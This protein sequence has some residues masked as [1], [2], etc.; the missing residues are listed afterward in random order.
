[1]NSLVGWE[2]ISVAIDD[3]ARRYA[4][5]FA[6]EQ[7]TV[8]KGKQV[9]FNTLAVCALSH[10]L[11]WL[12]IAFSLSQSDCWQPNLRSIFN[13]SDLFLPD[14]GCLECRVIVGECEEIEIVRSPKDDCLGYVI[15]RLDEDLL[16]VNL[17]GFLS[18]DRVTAEVEIIDIDRLQSLDVLL[19]TIDRHRRVNNLKQWWVDR[20]QSEW[21]QPELLL[22]GSGGYFR[23]FQDKEIEEERQ[24]PSVSRGKIIEFD[25]DTR[26]VLIL[27]ITEISLAELDVFLRVY[28]CQENNYLPDGLRVE[29]RDENNILAMEAAARKSDRGLEL[30]FSCSHNEEFSIKMM[31]DDRIAI[32]NFVV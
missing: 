18:T 32:E 3:Y 30:V 27:A 8:A 25:R 19:E 2:S 1:M 22:S 6:A 15:V 7:V 5:Q 9:Y 16:K 23:S 20:F 12:S 13:L 14:L 21:Q 17:L 31:L 10:Y 29:L 28:P 26:I 24:L 11:G 4:A